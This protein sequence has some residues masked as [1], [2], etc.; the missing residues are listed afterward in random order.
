MEYDEY[1]QN[2]L[3]KIPTIPPKNWSKEHFDIFWEYLEAP[4]KDRKVLST[5]P[6]EKTKK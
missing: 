6:N 5:N 3:D 4:T 1:H 2:L